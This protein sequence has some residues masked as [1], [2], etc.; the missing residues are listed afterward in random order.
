MI[1]NYGKP[2]LT[3]HK[4]NCLRLYIELKKEYLIVYEKFNIA[5]DQVM[6]NI[7]YNNSFQTF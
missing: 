4:R 5:E 6:E 7:E 3:F 1:Y 2:Q